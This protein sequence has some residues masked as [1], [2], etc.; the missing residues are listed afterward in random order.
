MI[1][2]S[3]NLDSSMILYEKENWYFNQMILW[4]GLS[5][6][7]E[8]NERKLFHEVHLVFCCNGLLAH[9]LCI[10][11]F[12]Y[13]KIVIKQKKKKWKLLS[14][15]FNMY[16]ICVCG[17]LC[18]VHD[19]YRVGD[20][21]SHHC[22]V[23]IERERDRDIYENWK[24]CESK[25]NVEWSFGPFLK[26]SCNWN[27]IWHRFL[28]DHY[29]FYIHKYYFVLY[30]CGSKSCRLRVLWVHTNSYFTCFFFFFFEKRILH[31]L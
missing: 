25:L 1:L 23:V 16:N 26:N 24:V 2:V 29:R 21:T 14:L 30:D 4:F 15:K 11:S 20:I 10:H 9:K 7:K 5:H 6:F 13:S 18:I 3:P 12:I 27:S 17:C 19:T 31:V 8:K 22:N 28:V